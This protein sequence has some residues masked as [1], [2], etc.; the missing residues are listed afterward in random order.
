MH[1]LYFTPLFNKGYVLMQPLDKE[2]IESLVEKRLCGTITPEEQSLLEQWLNREPMEEITWNSSDLDES[3]FRERLLRRIKEDAGISEYSNA[4][5]N[6]LAL[7]PYRW[8]AAALLLMM[9]GSVGYFLFF[10]KNVSPPDVV[11]NKKIIIQ[12]IAPGHSGA[13]LTLANGK[14]VYIDSVGNGEIAVQGNQWIVKKNGQLIY[15]T[16]SGATPSKRGVIVDNNRVSNNTITTPR[17]R[18][19]QIVLSDGTKVWLNAA[20]SITFG[21]VFTGKERKVTVTGEVYFEVAKDTRR[22]FIVSVDKAVITVLGTHFDVMDY[23]DGERVKTTLLEGAVKVSRGGQQVIIKPGQQASFF[24]QSDAIYVTK[25]DTDQA[26]AWVEGKLSL[27][28]LGVEAIMRRL[29]R[30]Y[31]VDVEFDGPV[32]QGHFWGLIKRDITLSDMLR[33]LRAN[34]IN[35]NLKDKKI[36]VS[37]N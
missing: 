15:E 7:I 32:P 19:F 30:W 4:T 21:T 11:Q 27:D 1:G 13:I 34:G 37:N 25:V 31:D 16:E 22:P 12:D 2:Y 3:S 29:S 5:K 24:R 10:K 9:M 35:A 17:G 20:S 23:P 28:D 36:I 26:V 14:K 33:I 18:E 6:K 8:A